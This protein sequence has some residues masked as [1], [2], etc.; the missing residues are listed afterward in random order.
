[1]RTQKQK[2]LT[3]LVASLFIFSIAFAQR[4]KDRI[5]NYIQQYK[6]LA[7]AEMLRTGIPAS[8]TL[9][10]GL[11]E[12]GY[13]QSDL[14]VNG[15]NHFGIK[16]KTE[17]TGEKMYHDDDAKGECF[18][19]YNSVEES[20]KDHS[21]FLMGRPHYAFLFKLDPTDY[22]GWA[23]GLKKAGY[24]TN[25]AYA[26]KLIKF[27][28]E[29]NLQE[30]TLLAL[31]DMPHKETDNYASVSQRSLFTSLI[32]T[33]IKRTS[34]SN[35]IPARP[36]E[37]NVKDNILYPK[38]K[39]FTINTSR[40]LFVEAGTSLLAV[41]SNNGVAYNRLLEFNDLNNVDI[42]EK[43]QLIFL[44]K[45]QKKGTKDVHIVEAGENLHDI[46]QK[47]GVQLN[48]ILEFN[49]LAKNSTPAVGERLYLKATP[50]TSTKLAV[51]STSSQSSSS[52]E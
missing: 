39:A 46:S 6:E 24:A 35:I 11:L 30:Y 31:E 47:E 42:V 13:G 5:E 17:W 19:K 3:S 23:H 28:E 40:V 44:E 21:N 18:R 36:I 26:Y 33:S 9:A 43:D 32:D 41:A 45:K 14:A 16:C 34:L 48:S 38:G 37:E 4:E 1:M 10:Q 8:I 27:I 15:N 49:K 7:V 22:Q 52:M 29:N 12:T 50:A 2:F 25:P 20:Y 51:T